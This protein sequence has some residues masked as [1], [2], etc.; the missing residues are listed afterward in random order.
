LETDNTFNNVGAGQYP[1]DPCF[2]D[3]NNQTGCGFN[4]LSKT[5]TL[6]GVGVVPLSITGTTPT[7]L[8]TNT[9]T[10]TSALRIFPFSDAKIYF[11]AGTTNSSGIGDF[12]FSSMNNGNGALEILNSVTP[13]NGFKVTGGNTLV[14]PSLTMIGSD[15][16]IGMRFSP[17]AAGFINFTDGTDITKILAFQESGSATKTSLIIKTS[18][19]QNQSLTIP[20][21]IQSE[22]MAI[23]PALNFTSPA[24]Q[25][26]TTSTTPV[27]LGGFATFTPKVTGRLALT[28]SGS[29][30]S[31]II[32]DGCRI[33][34]R[35]GTSSLGA[36]GAALTGTLVGTNQKFIAGV[37]GMISPFSKEVQI[38][39]LTINQK[40]YIDLSFAAI[41]GSTCTLTNLDWSIFEL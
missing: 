22:T 26:G 5:I 18:Q 35:Y 7:I 33:D 40:Y 39:G 41:G 19:A 21:I 15:S 13:I 6:R 2:N 37:G 16:N 3:N 34:V 32:S 38:T 31:G 24:N 14:Y 23:K 17:K 28:V 12:I 1:Y 30:S 11:E 8:L 9:K 20:A 10:T 29:E 36:N 27:M 4:T 25:T